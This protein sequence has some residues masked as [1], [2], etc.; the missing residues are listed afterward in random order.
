MVSSEVKSLFLTSD[1]PKNQG[2]EYIESSPDHSLKAMGS[3]ALVSA[4]CRLISSGDLT[5]VKGR[6]NSTWDTDKKPYQIKLK[7][8]TSLVEGAEKSKTWVLLANAYDPTSLRNKVAFD[9]ADLIGLLGSPQS[10]LVDLYYD[11]DYRGTYLLSE[12]VEVGSGRVDIDSLDDAN[13]DANENIDDFDALP[14]VPT[15]NAYGCEMQ[16]VDGQKDPEDISGGYLLE[17]DGGYYL[18]E[19]SWFKATSG[20]VFVVKS[21]EYATRNEMEYISVQVEEILACANS[22]SVN[23]TTGKGLFD[24]IDK[25]SFVRYVMFQEWLKNPDMSRSSMFFYKMR[26]DGKLYAGP[27]WDYDSSFGMQHDFFDPTGFYFYGISSLL[28]QAPSFKQAL[29]EY[30]YSKFFN[31]S[32]S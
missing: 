16:Y 21:P 17:I 31:V 13:E 19:K 8:K 7:N 24:Y 26:G 14:V 22:N 20:L 3:I 23:P 5:Q 25:D 11:G 27:V 30:V 18:G 6:G 28:M 2:R 32:I 12:K 9:L 1:D 10:E 15:T 4:D 29:H